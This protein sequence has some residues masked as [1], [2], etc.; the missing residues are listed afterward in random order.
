MLQKIRPDAVPATSRRSFR[1]ILTISK[2]GSFEVRKGVVISG[3]RN[4]PYYHALLSLYQLLISGVVNVVLKKR[5]LF[6]LSRHFG[7][8]FHSI[9]YL[10]AGDIP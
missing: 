5:K 4:T 2:Y 1:N 7:L 10:L 6:F 8:P 9:A 3:N